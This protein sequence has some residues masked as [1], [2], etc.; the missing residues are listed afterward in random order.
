MTERTI[1]FPPKDV[2]LREDVRMLGALVGEM[3]RDQGGEDF[4]RRVEAARRT[5]I[6]R[7][8]ADPTAEP[9]LMALLE[10]LSPGAAAA[11]VRGFAAYFQ[12]VNVA[13]KVHRIRR[14][15]DYLREGA[16]QPGSLEDAIRRV[17]ASGCSTQHLREV[18]ESVSIEPVF[19]AHPSEA[20]RQTILEKEQRIARCLVE[21]LDPSRTVPEER[22]AMA[23]IRSEITSIWQTETH[24]TMRPTVMDELDHALFYV[25]HIIYDIIPPFYE[26]VAAAFDSADG[27]GVAPDEWPRL[28]RC[29]SWIGG[30]M[31]GNPNVTADTIREA[32]ARHRAL[33]IERYQ[34]EVL[35]LARIL[36]QSRSRI[37]VAQDIGERCARYADQFPDAFASVPPRHRD[38]PYR[39]LF[40]LIA[41]RLA[42]TLDESRAGYPDA[43]AFEADL[44]AVAQSL[45]HHKGVHAG[46]FAVKRAIRR[47]RTFGF[48]LLTLDVRQDA[49]VHRAVLGRLLDRS[50][51]ETLPSAERTR[52]LRRALASPD[53]PPGQTDPEAKQALD[54]FRA[55]AE[56]HSRFGHRAIGPFITSMTQGADDVLS[57][58]ALARW[59][60]LADHHGAVP[61]D[62]APLFETVPDLQNAPMILQALADDPIYRSHL[63]SRGNRQVVMVGYSDSNKDGGLVASRWALHESQAAMVDTVDRAGIQLTVFHGRGGTIGRGGGKEDRA[64]QAAARGAVRGHLRLTEQGEV[65]NAK[66]GLRAI[67]LRSLE[68]VTAAVIVATAL[69]RAAEPREA[70]WQAVMQ[71]LAEVSRGAYRALVYD[72]PGFVDYFRE[73]TPID[74]IERMQIASRPPA[75]RSRAGIEDLRAIPWVFAWT[76]S[77]HLLPGWYG[78][79]QGLEVALEHHGES[80][81]QEM[82]RDWPFLRAVLDD[83][84]MV[85]AKA[86]MAI[87]AHY[88][89]L[90][91]KDSRDFFPRIRKEFDRTVDLIL[92]LKR[93]S[94]LLDDDPVL[95][96]SIRLRNPYVDP[97]SLLQIDLLARWRASGR[98]DPELF[99][100][101]LASVNGI[102]NGLQ[103]TG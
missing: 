103:N 19:T 79:G 4:Y 25:D 29:A 95:Q 54:V 89:Q 13:E 38:M 12:V 99:R 62:V 82:A 21:R 47:V 77:R 14:R 11:L 101:L 96:R 75:R 90:A 68:Q 3:L 56:C 39:V 74:V 69:P 59:S 7:R 27:T 46:L 86:D 71:Q 10:D 1:L 35:G 102:A 60:G 55:I 8:E 91:P 41:A 33:I 37:E 42:A 49:R 2:P 51:W 17:R 9:E 92:R 65:I 66:Y 48:H 81:L 34:A 85:L 78:L 18:L 36:S 16:V 98:T 58:L 5:A 28:V 6:R 63:E 31:D 45:T 24:P 72:S 53:P 80:M 26:A 43:A 84:E 97:M 22:T 70:A 100:A 73:A 23:R 57:V 64:I 87:A 61:L 83:A 50:D 32:L 20:T 76:Q 40:H 94:A 67:A 93:S 15:R 44:H 30:D 52:Q 88:A